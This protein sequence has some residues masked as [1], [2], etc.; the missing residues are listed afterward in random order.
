MSLA[1]KL[2]RLHTLF[3]SGVMTADEY[4]KAKAKILHGEVAPET[5]DDNPA[6]FD[7]ENVAGHSLGIQEERSKGTGYFG[8]SDASRP[9]KKE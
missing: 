9:K 7:W 6:A 5:G 4:Q 8:F 3:V 2:E 1:D